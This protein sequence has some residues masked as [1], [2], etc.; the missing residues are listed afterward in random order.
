MKRRTDRRRNARSPAHG[1]AS[2]GGSAGALPGGQPD[3]AVLRDWLEKAVEHHRAGRLGDAERLY[4]SVLDSH[5]DHPEALH[6]LGLLAFQAGQA[7][8]AEP[9]VRRAIGVSP[10]AAGYRDTLGT[11]LA[12]LGRPE[13]AVAAHREALSLAADRPGILFNLGNALDAADRPLEAVQQFRAAL[14]LDPDHNK[15]R[16]NLANVLR[17]LGHTAEAERCY[18]EVIAEQPALASAYTNLAGLLCDQN[19]REEAVALYRSVVER[20][21]EEARAHFNLGAALQ[22]LGRYEEAELCYRQA[23]RLEPTFV[24][25]L[26]NLGSV[27]LKLKARPQ[28]AACHRE[29]LRHAPASARAPILHNLGNALKALDDFPNAEA[30]FQAA[31]AH[32]P[33]LADA[34]F[35]LGLVQL[36]RGDLAQ[37]WTNY[38]WRFVSGNA[39]PDRRFTVPRWGGPGDRA[40]PLLLWREQGVGDEILFASCYGDV[41]AVQRAVRIECD[42]R[43]VAVFR[44][45]L[46]DLPAAAIQPESRA[47]EAGEV[48]VARELAAGRLPGLFRRALAAF[49]R[50]R[51]FLVP[52][53]SALALWRDRLGRLGPGLKVGVCWRSSLVDEERAGNYTT[54]ADWRPVFAV[55][56]V[57]F[58]NLQY[59]ADAGE[60]AD[61]DALVSAPLARWA[62]LDL[63]EQLDGFLALVANLD[64]VITAPTAVGELAAG[65]GTPTWR[66]SARNDWSR[67]GTAVRPWYPAMRLFQP[68]GRESLPEVLVRVARAL[69]GLA[70]W[71]RVPG[72]GATETDECAMDQAVNDGLD[73]AIALHRQGHLEAAERHYRSLLEQAPRHADGLNLLG[74]LLYQRGRPEEAVGFLRR[75]VTEMPEFAKAHHHLGLALQALGRKVEAVACLERALSITPEFPEA[76]T[77][78]GRL[79]QEQGR[80]S[81]AEDLHRQALTLNPDL[82]DAH[83]N[84]GYLFEE[85]ARFAEA[86]ACYRRVV[87]LRPQLAEAHNNLGMAVQSRNRPALTHFEQ[88]LTLDPDHPLAHWNR[89]LVL[90]AAGNLATGWADYDWRFQA[91]QLQ[92]GRTLPLPLWRGEGLVQPGGHE[93]NGHFRRGEGGSLRLMV[94]GEQGLGDEILFASCYPDLATLD[95]AVVAEASARL[96]PLFAR[97]FPHL[98]VRPESVD[99][100]RRELLDRPDADLQVAAGSLPRLTRPTLAAFPMRPAFLKPDAQAAALW[101]ARVV[102]LG[103]GLK[104][105]LCWRSQLRTAKRAGAYTALS[106]WTPLLGLTGCRYVNLQY[107]DCDA[108]LAALEEACGLRLARW[109]DLDLKMDLDGTAALMA[110]LDLVI[111]APTVIGEMAAALGVPVWRVMAPGTDWT[112][113]GTAVRPWFPTQRV[114]LAQEGEPLGAVAGRVTRTLQRLLGTGRSAL[115]T[116]PTPAPEPAS[117]PV[118]LPASAPEPARASAPPSRAAVIVDDATVEAWLTEAV[119]L[120]QG[121]QP[122]QAEALYRR[123]LDVRPN[124]PV[125]LHLLGVLEQQRGNHETAVGWIEKAVTA[126]PA[127]FAALLNLGNSL[128]ALARYEEAGRRFEAALRLRPEAAE[129]WT[130]LGNALEALGRL[131]DAEVAHRRCLELAP[132]LAAAHANLAAVLWQCDRLD[133]AE[134]HARRSVALDPRHPNDLVNLGTVLREQGRLDEAEQVYRAALDLEPACAEAFSD[135]GRLMAQRRRFPLAEALLRQALALS[136]GL[137]S[138]RFNLGL[139]CLADGRLETGWDGY[140]AR[141]ESRQVG[142]RGRRSSRPLWQGE[143]LEGKRLLIWPEQG[144]GD[145]LMFAC[146]YPAVMAAAAERCRIE[147]DRRLVPLLTRTLP[148]ADILGVDRTAAAAAPADAAAFDVHVPAGSLAA[149]LR[150][151]LRDWPPSTPALIVGQGRVREM[152]ARLAPLR[153]GLLVGLC[154]R[155]NRITAERAGQYAPLAQWEPILRIDGVSFVSLQYDADEAELSAVELRVGRSIARWPDLDLKQ[156]QEGVAALIRCLDLVLSAPTAVGEMAGAVGTPVWRVVTAPDW[157]QLGTTCRPWFPSMRVITARGGP[158]T[159]AI[160]SVA[161]RLCALKP[162]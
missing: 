19:R 103:P 34:A 68:T 150:P 26:D 59:D 101:R 14:A 156:D 64:L 81:E 53:E 60:L 110:A 162:P 149:I 44:R 74:I 54:V 133:E 1:G 86:E 87:E 25:A 131:A 146:L 37:G 143:A 147:A 18:R 70:R 88:A 107:G 100:N 144:L 124:Q 35:N 85:Q 119:G 48:A 55:P 158:V 79:R 29:A 5:P 127:Y 160:A 38:D 108:E 39:V 50:R 32:D 62:D 112:V 97:S 72:A 105:G 153:S 15:A 40:G 6:L 134:A 137:P 136:P 93:S 43:L 58:V 91:K 78:L 49:P 116:P 69:G 36:L 140:A 71:G 10:D 113:L 109:S 126:A 151:K 142:T 45:S 46:A 8:A 145:E 17:R 20:T 13:E 27:L 90:L 138:A 125:A 92:R 21:T 117:A 99:A 141:F 16:F 161:R 152:E 76:L 77:H 63:K 80:R 130:N 111:T 148:T 104:I 106:D 28:A 65:V 115:T 118:P 121:G 47:V 84:L 2:G 135:L 154:W 94:W 42:P 41:V 89:G 123:V 67:L 82:P 66:F 155:S 96:V 122:D 73:A 57:T 98:S 4:R 30:S 24:E 120:H 3:G 23:V 83:T 12:A 11:I 51:A 102:A 129:A 139:L 7:A 56:G 33:G 95:G 52:E 114:F 22:G 9:L 75:A 157:T 132:R 159:E 128:H 31:I 61:A